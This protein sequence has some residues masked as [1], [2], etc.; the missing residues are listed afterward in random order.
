MLT[1]V[2]VLV[3][4]IEEAL[5]PI[6]VWLMADRLQTPADGFAMGILSGAGYALFENLG[7]SVSTGTEWA[8][9]LTARIGT[10]LVHVL[11]T[12]LVGWA[13]VSAWRERKFLRL[14]GIFALAIFLHGTWNALSILSTGNALL[15]PLAEN[16]TS[17]LSASMA[18]YVGMGLLVIIMLILLV[19]ANRN[20]RPRPLE[21]ALE[22]TV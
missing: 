6:G 11:S 22:L 16:P 15:A 20:L 18:S 8:Q 19:I 12:G 3:P 7:I 14:G 1:F 5:K 2:S 17:A 13:L 10:S 4:L 9:I 21:A